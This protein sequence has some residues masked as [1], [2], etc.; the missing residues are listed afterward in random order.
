[1]TRRPLA[2]GGPDASA[3]WADAFAAQVEAWSLA[4]GAPP[5]HAQLARRAARA[6]LLAMQEGHVC[7]PLGTLVDACLLYTS[8]SPRDVEESRMPSSA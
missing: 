8:P 1:M 6:L 4:A 2:V 5:P 7:L 3:R